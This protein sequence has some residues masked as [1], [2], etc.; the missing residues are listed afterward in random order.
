MW[1]SLVLG[2]IQAGV[3]IYGAIQAGKN[4]PEPVAITNPPSMQKSQSLL[5]DQIIKDAIIQS[6]TQ[7][8]IKAIRGQELSLAR[9]TYMDPQS[10]FMAS[11]GIND[12][13]LSNTLRTDSQ[14][15]ENRKSILGS[16]IAIDQNRSDLWKSIQAL[17]LEK[18]RMDQEQYNREQDAWG[19]G[20]AAGSTNITDSLI[21]MDSKK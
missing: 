12:R 17:K 14:F 19:G 1:A 11:L 10:R 8:E 3:S 21:A 2:A 6:T 13:Y 9:N 20:I 4:K 15:S 5:D 16:Q 18:L 7:N